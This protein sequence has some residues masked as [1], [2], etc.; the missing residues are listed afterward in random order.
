MPQTDTD[1]NHI[2][3]LAVDWLTRDARDLEGRGAR[4]KHLALAWSLSGEIRFRD[5]ALALFRL[6]YRKRSPGE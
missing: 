5:Q 2:V 6:E 1:Q 4:V 3:E